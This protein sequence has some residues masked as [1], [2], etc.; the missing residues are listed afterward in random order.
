MPAN[1]VASGKE[2]N[3]P[4]RSYVFIVGRDV[5]TENTQVVGH[6]DLLRGAQ[7]NDPETS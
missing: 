6:L 1:I 3:R 4:T 2:R 7:R 5:S